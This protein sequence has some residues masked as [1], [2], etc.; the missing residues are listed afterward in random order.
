MALIQ[1]SGR[2]LAA[3]VAA[4]LALTLS[5]P[6]RLLA[7]EAIACQED[8]GVN[9]WQG[10]HFIDANQ[11]HGVSA[12]FEAQVLLQCT[13]PDLF[14]TSGSFVFS[15]ITPTNGGFYDILQMGFGVCRDWG[16][17]CHSSEMHY[18]IG[19][20]RTTS[21]PGCAGYSSRA[22][23]PTEVGIWSSAA[24]TLKV[25]HTA[26]YWWFYDDS[27]LETSLSESWVCWT[28]KQAVWFAETFDLGDKM[29]GSVGNPFTISSMKYSN[30]EGGA[31]FSTPFA[32]SSTCN[33]HDGPNPFDCSVTSATS[34]NIW[35]KPR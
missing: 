19:Y 5:L 28:P 11:K 6:P 15:N 27:T 16:A 23:L 1:P 8:S 22:P 34:I 26:N 20:G 18:Y 9:R 24:H 31:F 10:Q 12:V 30:V 35:T 21:T 33:D 14:E 2:R 7:A 32:V 25:V 4:S 3:F 29:G 17:E 13:Q